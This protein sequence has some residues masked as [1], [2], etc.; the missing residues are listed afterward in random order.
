MMT[1]VLT[2]VVVALIMF[3]MAI[4]VMVSGRRLRG[5]CGGADCHCRAEGLSPELC[6]RNQEAPEGA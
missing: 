1:V 4:G 2:V 6:E 3:A 5:S